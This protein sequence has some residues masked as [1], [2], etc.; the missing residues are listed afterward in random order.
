M[1]TFTFSIS[2]SG[3][4]SS[5]KYIFHSSVTVDNSSS[6]MTC[7]SASA[8]RKFLLQNMHLHPYA[9]QDLDI[10]HRLAPYCVKRGLLQVLSSLTKEASRF[11]KDTLML[12]ILDV[13]I[14]FLVVSP[15]SRVSRV[16]MFS[17]H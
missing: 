4:I 16:R 6:T 15:T 10:E 8:S 2:S 17:H 3:S 7:E 14:A 13:L 5:S 11:Q 9:Q 1:S 12:L